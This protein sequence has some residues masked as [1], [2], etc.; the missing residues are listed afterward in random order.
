MNDVNLVIILSS[1]INYPPSIHTRTLSQP[2]SLSLPPFMSLTL[3]YLY[4]DE[5]EHNDD[6]KFNL[7]LHLDAFPCLLAAVNSAFKYVLQR[8][9]ETSVHADL[10]T[11][12]K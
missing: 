1:Y 8:S 3:L 7:W 12:L 11:P 10:K 5:C 9:G 4:C 6:F 2:F